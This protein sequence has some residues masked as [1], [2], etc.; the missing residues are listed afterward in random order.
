MCK[1]HSTKAP[2]SLTVFN[3]HQKKEILRA[4]TRRP[5]YPV[6]PCDWGDKGNGHNRL[7]IFGPVISVMIFMREKEGI[8]LAN[9]TMWT[10]ESASGLR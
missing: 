3:Q 8:K 10:T 9:D 5:R 2:P 6:P 4:T 1:M 7:E